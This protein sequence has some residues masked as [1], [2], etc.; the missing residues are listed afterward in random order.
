MITVDKKADKLGSGIV[1]MIQGAKQDYINMSTSY[2]RKELTGYSKDQVDKWDNLWKVETGKKYIRVV[3]ENGV[4]CFIVREDSG[5]FKKGD[6][7]KAAG[8]NKPALNSPRGN[9]LSGNY[10]I[11]WTGPLYLK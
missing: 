5:K 11:Q 7:L 1:N 9:I 4:F 10:P 3:R 2:G 8:Y 6:I